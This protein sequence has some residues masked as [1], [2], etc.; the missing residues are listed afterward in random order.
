MSSLPEPRRLN[1][2]PRLVAIAAVA[3]LLLLAGVTGGIWA[4]YTGSSGSTDNQLLAAPDWVAPTV[5][6]SVIGK[7]QGGT[8]GYIHQGGTYHAY[9]NVSDSGAPASGVAGVTGNLSTTSTGLMSVALPSGSYS[10]GGAG[11]GFRSA[12]LTANSTLAEG[13]YSYSLTSTDSN[14][15]ARTQSGYSVIVDNTVPTASDVQTTNHTGNTVG[16]PEIGDTIVFTFSEPIDPNS[17]LAGWT[18]APTSA[19][20]RFT[21]ALGDPLTVYNA[22][23]TTQL[24]LGS[25]DMG[26][27]DY[28]TAATTF[29]VTGTASSMVLSGDTITVTLGTA[30]TPGP[31]TAAANGTMAWS[32]SAAVTDRA[33]NAE[34][35]TVR[36]E[37]GTAQA[38]TLD[39]EF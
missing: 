27:I 5:A 39:K 22:A 35:V 9:A 23:N 25:V 18:G 21:N 16:K 34:T 11:Y 30:S 8:P 38:G 19:V 3:G 31:T 24:P 26:R 7:T 4:Q 2:R 15:N 20:V 37:S 1:Q 32:P 33:G 17:I 29:G 6:S 28:V 13:A 10:I 14:G 36:N 12:S